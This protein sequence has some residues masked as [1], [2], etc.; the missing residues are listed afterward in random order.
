MDHVAIY[1]GTLVFTITSNGYKEFTYNLW[2]QLC[3]LK[4]AWTLLIVCLDQASYDYFQSD[5]VGFGGR[6][7]TIMLHK[8]V[9]GT[10][11]TQSGPAV[12]GSLQ[13]KRLVAAKLDVLRDFSERAQ[14]LIYMDSDMMIRRD[15]VPRMLQLLEESPLWFQCDEGHMRSCSDPCPDP[16][17]GLI[18][19]DCSTLRSQL[20]ELFKVGGRDWTYATS[21]QD[22][23]QRRLGHLGLTFRVLPRAEFPNGVWRKAVPPEAFL[24]HFNHCLGSEKKQLMQMAGAWQL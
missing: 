9:A 13:F 2:R 22:Y 14:R 12:F 3:H 8:T 24:L 15:P 21:D 16:C 4:T 19:A 18:V 11:A 10:G 20:S 23:V 6:M 17:T 5:V 7:P 1:D